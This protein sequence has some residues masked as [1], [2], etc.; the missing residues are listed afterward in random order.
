MH[1]AC[2]FYSNKKNDCKLIHLKWENREK[3]TNQQQTPLKC[4]ISLAH[5]NTCF[6]GEKH[7]ESESYILC[8]FWVMSKR[9]SSI[10]CH[11]TN[12]PKLD[13]ISP[14]SLAFRSISK[15]L[16][17]NSINANFEMATK[18]NYNFYDFNRTGNWNSTKLKRAFSV[19]AY[20]KKQHF[21]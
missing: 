13:H 19:F 7:K 18:K 20:T 8:V 16:E 14:L 17:T 3:K 6:I 21:C 15:R 1:S 10:S 12:K 11:S 5:R 9:A 4:S 2:T